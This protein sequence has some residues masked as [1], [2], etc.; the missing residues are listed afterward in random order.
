[1]PDTFQTVYAQR[2]GPALLERRVTFHRLCYSLGSA[3]SAMWAFRQAASLCSNDTERQHILAH[4]DD[5]AAMM[6]RLQDEI[7]LH[8]AAIRVSRSGEEV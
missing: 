6:A 4:A 5:F 2:V 3:T 1:M 7:E 8:A